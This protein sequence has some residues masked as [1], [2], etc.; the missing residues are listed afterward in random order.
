[1]KRFWNRV[2]NLLIGR[3]FEAARNR[4]E[5]AANRLDAALREV[6]KQ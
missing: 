3:A 4:N 5:E 1:M 2:R 6:T